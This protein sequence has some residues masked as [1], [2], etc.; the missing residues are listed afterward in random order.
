MPVK[1]IIRFSG[2]YK[3]S[4]ERWPD[5]HKGHPY[6]LSTPYPPPVRGRPSRRRAGVSPYVGMPLVGVRLSSSSTLKCS[7]LELLPTCILFATQ[8]R[9]NLKND[10]CMN[11]SPLWHIFGRD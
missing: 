7:C 8:E 6:I 3:N 2:L 10:F 11:T 1:P 5:A 4:S 9:D